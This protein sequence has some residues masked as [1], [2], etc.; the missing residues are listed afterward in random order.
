MEGGGYPTDSEYVEERT[1]ACNFGAVD[2]LCNASKEVDFWWSTKVSNVAISICGS[3]GVDRSSSTEDKAM[4]VDI[5]LLLVAFNEF[6]A[7]IVV[8]NGNQAR[9][10]SC[11]NSKKLFFYGWIQN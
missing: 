2:G 9:E 1:S 6:L 3:L 5:W 11:E 4:T 8:F 7:F 10:K